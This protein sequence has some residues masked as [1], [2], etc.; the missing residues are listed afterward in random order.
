MT[1]NITELLLTS[2]EPL[3][4]ADRKLYN[5]LLRHAYDQLQTTT[6]FSMPLT[7][8]CG[9]YG[10]KVPT[11]AQLT[12]ST[13][14]LMIT[15]ITYLKKTDKQITQQVVPLLAGVTV[16][17]QRIQ[18]E[19]SQLIIDILT[20]PLHLE[21][22]LIQAH[23][24]YKYSNLLYELLAT[25][26]YAGNNEHTVEIGEL[27]KILR[28]PDN[29]MPNFTDFNRFVL[30]PSVKEINCYASFATHYEMLRKGRKVT[31]LNFIFNSKVNI[32]AQQSAKAVI[33]PRRPNLFIEDPNLE[34]T[35]AFLLNT[36]TPTRR[37]Y[38]EKA[39]KTKQGQAHLTEAD[40]DRPDSWYFLI[41]KD[42]LKEQS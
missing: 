33:P 39:L 13:R 29:K 37:K 27:R 12:A 7:E 11:S 34:W 40:F 16:S 42:V 5:Y 23:F 30:T 31:H 1:D 26:H 36:D 14:R 35:Y 9:V 3:T 17:E 10:T 4:L 20:N 32:S 2:S 38:F 25:T 22:C 21:R 15:T 18:Y 28:I 8:L 24:I 6:Q 41:A 19:Y